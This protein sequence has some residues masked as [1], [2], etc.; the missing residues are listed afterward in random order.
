MLIC[1]TEKEAF[2]YDPINDSYWDLSPK[3]KKYSKFLI[4]LVLSKN[5]MPNIS[6]R[7]FRIVLMRNNE[8]RRFY[9]I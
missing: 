9:H 3:L 8:R 2:V 7:L 5:G 4:S 6:K 1:L